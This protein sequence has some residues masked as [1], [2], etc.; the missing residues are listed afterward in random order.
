MQ[1][2]HKEGIGDRVMPEEPKYEEPSKAIS[3]VAKG[4][5]YLEF[6]WISDRLVFPGKIP[7]RQRDREIVKLALSCLK[8]K[9][10]EM[11]EKTG[12]PFVPSESL[13]VDD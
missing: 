3:Y 2:E 6:Q 8:A 1:D 13:K 9:M 12:R 10:Q 11:Q 5:E 4:E 7:A